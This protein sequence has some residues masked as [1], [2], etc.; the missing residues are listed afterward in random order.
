MKKKI[1]FLFTLVSLMG[2][3]VWA[4]D[5]KDGVYQIGTSAELAEFAAL[6]NE[7]NTT[8]NAVLTSDIDFSANSEM[9]GVSDANPFRG[10]FDGGGHTITLGYNTT[11]PY[12]GLFSFVNGV[13]IKNLILDG[14][15]Q[16]SQV[17]VGPVGANAA[18][19]CTF[20]N[21]LSAVNV[22]S[23]VVGPTGDTGFVGLVSGNI[24]FNDCGFVGSI[25]GESGIQ[26]GGFVGYNFAGTSVVYNNCVVAAEFNGGID[27]S[28]TFTAGEGPRTFNNCYYLN[29]IGAEQGT[30]MSAEQFASGEVAVKLGAAFRQNI[31]ED[32][33]PVLDQTHGIVKEITSVGYAT[34]YIH[35][36]SVTI[37]AGVEAFTGTIAENYL[38][39]NPIESVVIKGQAVVLK[40]AEGYYS[41]IPTEA[42]FGL[43]QSDLIGAEEDIDAAGKYVLAQVDDKV[44][45][46]KATTGTIKAGKA[47]LESAS[48]VKAFY[49]S[50]DEAT[51][52]NEEL[53][54]KN[55]EL[56]GATIYNLAGQRVNKT[57]KG[58][59]IING[60]KVLY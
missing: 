50:G 32:S 24:I 59:Y 52:I 8:V 9:I 44:G 46:Y 3:K 15:I 26:Y 33:Y 23:T 12:T 35:E 25:N 51:S 27:R 56:E 40:G 17:H 1:F 21:I 48:G 57:Q 36:T 49:F 30:Q 31:G 6:V 13:T 22:I 28:G 4:L 34:M 42:G 10:T 5:Q 41:F 29:A 38:V 18:G 16:S 54:I 58:V 7:G 11:T 19:N 60:K 55:E 2:T 39:L 14:S 47:Y 37:P 45:F 20:S 53:R 43:V